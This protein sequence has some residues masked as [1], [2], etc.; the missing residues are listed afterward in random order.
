MKYFSLIL[1]TLILLWNNPALALGLGS[2]ISKTVLGERLHIEIPVTGIGDLTDEDLKIGIAS[3]E[4]YEKLDV[5]LQAMHQS[6]QFAIERNAE[7]ATLII[8]SPKSIQE[9][10]VHFLVVIIT[11]AGTVLKDVSVL[12]DAPQ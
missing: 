2:P 5:E 4:I 8:T 9:P 10:Y 7:Q 3:K 1:T 12:L 6:L 11:P